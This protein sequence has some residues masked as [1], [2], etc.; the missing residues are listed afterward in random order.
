MRARGLTLVELLVA[1]FLATLVIGA[2]AGT[3]IQV[4]ETIN[5]T[6]TREL[7][8]QQARAL[9]RDI[10]T[11]LAR[12][13]PCTQAPAPFNQDVRNAGAPQRPI[14]LERVD[15][16]SVPANADPAP[17]PEPRRADRLRIFTT[18]DGQTAT[19]QQVVEYLLDQQG[20]GPL[21][22]SP[23]GSGY[24]SG[25]LRRQVWKC[26][27]PDTGK[28]YPDPGP[29]CVEKVVSFQL[30]WVDTKADAIA[31]SFQAPTAATSSG[32]EFA[33]EG[34]FAI[35]D[36]QVSASDAGAQKLLGALPIG[37]ELRLADPAVPND[38]G[39]PVLV[40]RKNGAGPTV[41][42]V[43]VNDRLD[44]KAGLKGSAFLPPSLVRVTLVLAWG[45]GQKSETGRF[46]R[47][48]PVSR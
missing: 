7:G 23:P 24:W 34:V 42:S 31:P 21:L 9:F 3:S 45:K 39:V 5:A 44:A 12:L 47:S 43:L 2:I 36:F 37:G 41:P 28:T 33:R 26:A 10:E 25:R 32:D 27:P 40:R 38:P 30:D 14:A 15:P 8:A 48:F 1:I 29:I 11:D 19:Q 22:Q 17:L 20:S 46:V 16:T 6:L 35:S 4:Q 13:V 18:F